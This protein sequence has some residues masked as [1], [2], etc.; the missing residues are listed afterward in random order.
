MKKALITGITGQDGSYLSEHLLSLG[1]EVHGMVRRSSHDTTV[2][3]EN[4]IDA[5]K[6]DIHYGDLR[7]ISSIERILEKSQPDEIYNLAAQSH[8]RISFDCPEETQEINYYG[9]GRLV[10]AATSLNP[11]VRLYQASTSEMFGKTNPPQNEQSP[12]DPVSPYA[13]SKL[14]A[15]EDFIVGYRERH[16]YYLTSGILFNHESPRRGHNF[17]TR[18]ITTG[19]ARIKVGALD[20]LSLGNLEA[21]RDWGY[22]GDYVKAMHSIL[23]Q[24]VPEDFVIGTGRNHSV[25]EFIE[26]AAKALSMTLHW[27][28]TGSAEVAKDDTG[29][30]IIKIDEKFYRP[31]EVDHLR[32]DASKAKEKLGWT[33]TTTFEELVAMMAEADFKKA[34]KEDGP[35]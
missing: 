28:G 22:A 19:L 5:G 33:P 4:A 2:Y 29:K 13:E 34:Q 14:K 11:K 8:V 23:Q 10:N 27:E 1:Y 30:I 35:L 25:K 24:D 16:G 32:A 26:A 21:T 7:D 18:K 31:N 17:V 3:I 6:I 12:F 9:V 20:V 15:H